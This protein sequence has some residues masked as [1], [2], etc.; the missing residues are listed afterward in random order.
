[1]HHVILGSSLPKRLAAQV[2]K[3]FGVLGGQSEAP[4]A[5]ARVVP[6]VSS[7]AFHMQAA[8]TG[9]H[10][11]ASTGLQRCH[12]GLCCKILL[13][14]SAHGVAWTSKWHAQNG[15][16]INAWPAMLYAYAPGRS[17]RG[18][19]MLSWHTLANWDPHAMHRPTT[20]NYALLA[21]SYP[22]LAH[23]PTFTH[24]GNVFF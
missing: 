16:R 3:M 11:P 12:A 7:H 20:N 14:R 13:H 6:Q 10:A 9:S 23:T 1:M 18:A 4:V 21:S 19:T 5:G 22:N 24:V 8:T 17:S 15:T 2:D